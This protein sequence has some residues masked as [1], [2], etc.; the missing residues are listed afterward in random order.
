MPDRHQPPGR[1]REVRP[2]KR[3]VHAEHPTRPG[4]ATVSATCAGCGSRFV[5]D[6]Q[7]LKRGPDGKLRGWCSRECRVAGN[8]A[9]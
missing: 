3:P 2:K 6:P 8:E 7:W 9:V 5:A 1:G 4:W